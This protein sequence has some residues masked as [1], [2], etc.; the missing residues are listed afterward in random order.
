MKLLRSFTAEVVVVGR[1]EPLEGACLSEGVRFVEDY[2]PGMGP[3]GGIYTGLSEAS[4]FHSLV[5]ACDMPFLNRSLLEYM[6][7]LA[8]SYDFIVPRVKGELE[9]LH[10]VYSKN[11]LE[12]MARRLRRGELRIIGFA[13]EVRVRIVEEAE[14]DRFDPEHLSFFNINT[15]DDL[16][17]AREL[18][19]AEKAAVES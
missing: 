3:L 19:G 1:R 16:R 5:V 2:I 10:A 4:S 15:A 7:E 6:V 18:L 17:R 14:M 9:P 11:C 12:P 8:P 13:E